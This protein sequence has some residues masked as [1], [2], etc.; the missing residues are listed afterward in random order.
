MR[1][2][3]EQPKP[4]WIQ[5]YE[6]YADITYQH[7]NKKT[8]EVSTRY[9]S[10]TMVDVLSFLVSQVTLFNRNENEY[11]RSISN[12]TDKY[13]FYSSVDYI[14]ERLR[15][16]RFTVNNAA[17][18]LIQLKLI[19]RFRSTQTTKWFIDSEAIDNLYKT[20]SSNEDTKSNMGEQARIQTE[21]EEHLDEA[22]ALI[23]AQANEQIKDET[24]DSIDE[25]MWIS[26]NLPEEAHDEFMQKEVDEH[27][28]VIEAIKEDA[29]LKVEIIQQIQ[30]DNIQIKQIKHDVGTKI[31]NLTVEIARQNIASGEL[32]NNG[33]PVENYEYQNKF[34]DQCKKL[35]RYIFDNHEDFKSLKD[36][37]I[38]MDKLQ[39]DGSFDIK[40][41]MD[42]IV[43]TVI[44]ELS[45]NGIIPM[46]YWEKFNIQNK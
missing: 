7:T 39:L 27:K 4:N 8:E 14:A 11:N 10:R 17:N 1:K 15:C 29:E 33:N 44:R 43:H 28:E 38:A 32:D 45:E 46:N 18:I 20:L 34:I 25:L 3:E 2:L 37:D 26:E 41:V 12:Q 5:Q 19:K 42:F 31:Y 16:S 36:L 21:I 9:L 23:A 6:W 13:H 30:D 24:S 22:K 35:Y 40:W